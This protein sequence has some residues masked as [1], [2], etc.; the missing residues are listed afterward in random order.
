M[1][2]EIQTGITCAKP[3][4]FTDEAAFTKHDIGAPYRNATKLTV[5]IN[6]PA[7]CSVRFF[8]NPSIERY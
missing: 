1:V 7:K 2:Y 4:L 3:I 6:I 8:D 5:K